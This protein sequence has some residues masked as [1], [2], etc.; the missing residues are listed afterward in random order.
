M[1]RVTRTSGF[2]T[3]A[4]TLVFLFPMLQGADAAP[5]GPLPF[6]AY[7]PGGDFSGDQDVTLEHVFL[8]WEDVSLESLAEADIYALERN[9]ALIVTIEPWTWTRDE[10]NTPEFLRKGIE[11]GYYDANMRTICQVIG[12]LQ[13][14]VSVRWAHEMDDDNCQFIWAGWEPEDYISA[15]HR[16]MDICRTEAPKINVLWSPFGK[17]GMEK[18]YPGDDFVDLVGI[19]I[20]GFEPYEKAAYGRPLTYDELLEERY[21]R[22]AAF[23]KPVIVAELGYS[24]SAA[25]VD[26]WE[27]RVRAARP[28]MPQLVGVS[29]FNQQEVYAWPDGFGLPDWR[30][31][32]RE[33]K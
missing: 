23:G 20:F 16:M 4:L 9:R 2:R 15:F 7:D 12:T 13:S 24:G 21:A 10:R 27:Q 30:I 6:G 31:K 28:N 11:D 19:S 14:P 8:P 17:E 26:S 33:L 25:Y 5:P 22:A 29:Y 18:Y 1:M 3:T 32:L